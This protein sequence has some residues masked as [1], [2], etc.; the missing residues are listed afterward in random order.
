M[1]FNQKGVINAEGNLWKSQRKFLH[2]KLSLGIRSKRSGLEKL[3]TTEV[4][5]F[6]T[7]IRDSNAE[8]TDLSP[9]FSVNISNVICNLLMSIKFTQNDPRFQRFTALIEEG[10]VLFGKINTVDYIPCLEY[11]PTTKSCKT[12]IAQNRL[13]MFNFYKEVIDEHRITFD[14]NNQR[15][16]VDAYLFEIKKAEEG[17]YKDQLFYGK[18]SE[19]QLMQVIGDIFS[20]GMETIKTTL[21]W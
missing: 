16:L 4:M 18:D 8:P 6:L 2:E 21:L 1:L 13:E 19:E 12:K 3:I 7:V 9:I 11:L 15:D 14:P 20:A 10:F 17:G 5:D